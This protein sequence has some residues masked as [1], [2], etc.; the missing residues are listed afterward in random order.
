MRGQGHTDLQFYINNG[1]A[2][3]VDSVRQTKCFF[4]TPSNFVYAEMT[5]RVALAA[6]IELYLN[7]CFCFNYLPELGPARNTRPWPR[8]LTSGWPPGLTQSQV[9]S[10][11]YAALATQIGVPTQ[12]NP[13]QG[14]PGAAQGAGTQIARP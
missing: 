3:H 13:A 12:L 4:E 5:I 1:F 6:Q 14:A 11:K 10:A 2:Q 7:S 9:P 8:G